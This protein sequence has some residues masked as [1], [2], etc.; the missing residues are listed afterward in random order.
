MGTGS[1]PPNLLSVSPQVLSVLN[2]FLSFSLITLP[3]KCL[4]PLQRIAEFPLLWHLGFLF[5]GTEAE[6]YKT[7]PEILWVNAF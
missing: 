4:S 5:L 3:F 2:S 7:V 1:S 6:M